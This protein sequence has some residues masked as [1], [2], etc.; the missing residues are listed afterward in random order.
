MDECGCLLGRL[1]TTRAVYDVWTREEELTRLFGHGSADRRQRAQ[2]PRHAREGIGPAAT[3]SRCFGAPARSCDSVGRV[4][5]AGRLCERVACGAR[6]PRTET[7]AE[8]RA[9]R[10]CASDVR[11]TD[12]GA[13]AQYPTCTCGAS[14]PHLQALPGTD[15]FSDGGGGFGCRRPLPRLLRVSARAMLRCLNSQ[16]RLTYRS[17]TNRN[18]TGRRPGRPAISQGRMVARP[19]QMRERGSTVDRVECP[20][21][22]GR[23]TTRG[24]AFGLTGGT[25]AYVCGLCH[26]HGVVSRAQIA[27]LARLRLLVQRVADLMQVGDADAAARAFRVAFRIASSMLDAEQ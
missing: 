22:C 8:P 23:G 3:P 4:T 12:C 7:P 25:A 6:R 17:L 18:V 24:R 20:V 5:G 19:M 13:R 2:R 1:S 16:S 21:C 9:R 14:P 10:Q 15:P 26:G 11:A 27:E